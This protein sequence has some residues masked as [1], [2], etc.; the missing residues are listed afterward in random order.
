MKT[1]KVLRVKT[2]A[3]AHVVVR[4]R[5]GRKLFEVY[6]PGV[7]IVLSVPPDAEIKIEPKGSSD[8]TSRG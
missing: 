4:N 6:M 8:V 2:E 3:A 5:S 1:A 7:T